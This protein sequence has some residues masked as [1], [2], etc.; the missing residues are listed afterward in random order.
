M[1]AATC[2]E[3][4]GWIEV[5]NRRFPGFCSTRC[6]DED[7]ARRDAL[8]SDLARRR[9]DRAQQQRWVDQRHRVHPLT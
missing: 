6:R 9:A 2:D 3:C 4:T 8:A 5:S 1:S 7:R